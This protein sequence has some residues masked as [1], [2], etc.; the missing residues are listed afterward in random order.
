MY[1][2]MTRRPSPRMLMGDARGSA[3]VG[4]ALALPLLMMIVSGLINYGAHM[5]DATAMKNGARAAAQFARVNPSDSAG[6]KAIA[7]NAGK[8]DPE[9]LTVTTTLFCECTSGIVVAC[10]TQCTGTAMQKFIR[11]DLKQS[12][13]P[14]IPY[15]GVALPSE[16]TGSATIRY[17]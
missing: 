12:Y 6:I 2:A 17:Q 13:I 3:A 9:R 1:P 14:I 5:V 8:L 4:F 7:A 11:I 15:P 16:T 10:T